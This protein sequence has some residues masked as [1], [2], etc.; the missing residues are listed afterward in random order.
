LRGS[1]IGGQDFGNLWIEV[2]SAPPQKF[3]FQLLLKR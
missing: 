2:Q 1:H 3:T